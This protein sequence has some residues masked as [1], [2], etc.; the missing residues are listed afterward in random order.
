[1]TAMTAPRRTGT[2][3]KRLWSAVTGEYELAPHELEVLRQ[4]VNCLDVCTELQATVRAQGLLGDDRVH[5]AVI[6]LRL[7]RALL[8]RLLADLRFPDP[9]E[10]ARPQRRSGSRGAYGRREST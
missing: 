2:A 5:P 1:M 4:A 8:V 7:Q 6:E 9:E 10:D 3:G